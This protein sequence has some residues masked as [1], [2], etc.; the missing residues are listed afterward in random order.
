MMGRKEIVNCPFKECNFI[1]EKD[2]L[3]DE[4]EMVN[5]P[6]NAHTFAGEG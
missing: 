5:C 4:E 1:G 2:D 3:L 6:F